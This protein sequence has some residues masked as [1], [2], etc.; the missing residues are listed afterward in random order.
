MVVFPSRTVRTEAVGTCGHTSVTHAAWIG[1]HI[2]DNMWGEITYPFPN[3]KKWKSNSIPLFIWACDYL[4]MLG[5][6]LIHVSKMGPSCQ[7]RACPHFV[8]VSR[9]ILNFCGINNL[10]SNIWYV[11]VQDW[12]N[13]FV[14]FQNPAICF[15]PMIIFCYQTTATYK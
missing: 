4:S 7:E 10:L 5:L 14:S 15:K 3:F 2:Y 1:N 13:N 6:G 12:W 9:N 11:H 8:V